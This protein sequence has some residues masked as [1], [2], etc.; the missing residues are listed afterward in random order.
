MS[1]EALTCDYCG[2]P[3]PHAVRAKQARDQASLEREEAGLR[4]EQA[5]LNKSATYALVWSLAGLV[6]CCL[7][8][9]AGVAVFMG[10]RVQTRAK[11]R[12][13][14]PPGTAT[15]AVVL[16]GIGLAMFTAFAIFAAFELRATAQR[17]AELH[18]AIERTAQAE[19]LSQHT[20]CALA[21]LRLLED[22]YA[23]HS[24]S[25][26]MSDSFE[27]AGRL[28]QVGAKATL[29][30]F[31]FRMANKPRT[32]LDACLERGARWHIVALVPMGE[33]CP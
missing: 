15:A 22:G 32:E 27:C 28:E 11:A 33:G 23:D 25:S 13:W 12:G 5:A 18:A 6:T 30:G 16:G 10:R 20:A 8:I 24:G 4:A 31:S 19:Q 7:P 2:A 14:V 26:T 29:H 21:E 1:L 17:K 3:S 9:P